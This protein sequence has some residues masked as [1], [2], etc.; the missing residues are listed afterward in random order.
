MTAAGAATL[1][2]D[3]GSVSPSPCG[4]PPE[5]GSHSTAEPDRSPCALSGVRTDEA[6]LDVGEELRDDSLRDDSVLA[7]EEVLAILAAA[8]F[9]GLREAFFGLD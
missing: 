3:E 5:C 9:C 8:G 6:T 2:G 1:T 7:L 4:S